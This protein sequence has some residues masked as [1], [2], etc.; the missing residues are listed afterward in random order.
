VSPT[1]TS[2]YAETLASLFGRATGDFKLGLEA[3]R[4]LF[5]A[6]GDPHRDLRHVVLVAGTNGK[7]STGALITA[8]LR[9]AGHRVGF[10]VSPHLM[11]FSERIRVDDECIPPADVVSLFEEIRA[12]ESRCPARPSFFEVTTAIAAMTFVRREVDVAVFEVGL[13]GRLDATNV[14]DRDLAVI[15]P[16]SFDHQKFLGNTLASIAAEKADILPRDGNAVVAAQPAEAMTVIEKFARERNTRLSHAPTVSWNGGLV[17]DGG[18]PL[19]AAEHPRYQWT[20]LATGV[21]ACRALD[22]GGIA[23]PPAAI[24]E[25]VRGFSWP[26][27]YHWVGEDLI[28]DGAHNP[29]AVTALL[30]AL[31]VDP[32]AGERPLHCV[33]SALRDKEGTAMVEML[34]AIAVTF[35]LCPLQSRRNRSRDELQSLA[36]GAPIHETVGAALEAAQKNARADGGLALVA[37]SLMLAGEALAAATG[38]ERDPPVDG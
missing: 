19:P 7:G 8:G 37:G 33:F 34:R 20:N 30:D 22:A 32:R 24:D 10:F 4:A 26:G 21:A 5:A 6:L 3:P 14:I 16:I 38:A 15:T 1:P 11:Q 13:G 12:I 29:A 36:P 23:C 35:Q 18:P 28:I 25:A 17:L 9:A 2:A 27:R 31:R